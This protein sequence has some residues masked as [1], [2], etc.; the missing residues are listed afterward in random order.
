MQ[1]HKVDYEIHGEIIPKG[2][3]LENPV[4]LSHFHNTNHVF[5]KPQHAYFFLACVLFR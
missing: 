2:T 4:H 5:N 1:C 3:V